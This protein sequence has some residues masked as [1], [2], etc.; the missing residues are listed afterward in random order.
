MQ[1]SLKK[2][3]VPECSCGSGSSVSSWG[4]VTALRVA[5]LFHRSVES[6]LPPLNKWHS[7][8]LLQFSLTEAFR[9]V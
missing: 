7:S 6:S 4:E 3:F 1:D 5:V 9:G 8:V 2:A